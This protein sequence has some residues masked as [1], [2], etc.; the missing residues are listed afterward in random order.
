MGAK[1]AVLGAGSWG[2]ALAAVAAR[3]GNEVLLWGRRTEQVRKMF[4]TRHN[5][6]YLQHYELEQGITPTGDL[7]EAVR[8][9]DV[10]LVAVASSGIRD[11]SGYLAHE[12]PGGIPVVSVTKGLE[13]GTDLRMTQ[14]LAERLGAD[15]EGLLC[16]LSGPNFAEEIIRGLPAG[17][18]V[19]CED[20]GCAQRVQRILSGP[21]LRV[22][23]SDD[24][25]GVELG[26]ALKNVYAIAVGIVQ[27]LGLGVNIQ[28]TL[29]TRGLAELA[30]LGVK[31]GAHPFTFAG[32]SGLGDMVLTCTSDL[33]RN[34]R[35]GLALGRGQG[36]E[37]VEAAGE[38][39]EGI[40]A[41]RAV[42]DLA[43]RCDVEMP[44]AEQLYQIL[45]AGK[46]PTA[47]VEELMERGARTE[48]E[49]EFVMDSGILGGKHP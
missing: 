33:S 23:T 6:D 5:P 35:A 19:A 44:I 42:R 13:P 47:A 11:F 29:I 3:R 16:A 27:S 22:Y 26:G 43:Q 30:R 15:S 40:R 14:V 31:M 21:C 49:E 18:V 38:T 2:T 1:V 46:T 20:E 39:V 34:R 12:Y 37:E 24:L 17:T 45:F 28:S 4:E 48:R 7:A 9:S 32:L 8:G 41:A 25:V 10:I 36:L